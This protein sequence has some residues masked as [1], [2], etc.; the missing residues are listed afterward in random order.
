MFLFLEFNM[1]IPDNYTWSFKQYA[2]S[3]LYFL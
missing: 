1:S 2:I 3:V